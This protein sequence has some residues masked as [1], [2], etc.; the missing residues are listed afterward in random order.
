MS[1]YHANVHE[2]ISKENGFSKIKGQN[3]CMGSE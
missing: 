1:Q 3:K 2:N